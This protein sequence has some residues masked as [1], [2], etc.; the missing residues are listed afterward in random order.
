MMYNVIKSRVIYAILFFVLSVLMIHLLKPSLIYD[1]DG[2]MKEFGT[3]HNKTLFSFGVIT[4]F[5]A[6]ISF[7][8]FTMIDIIFDN[9]KKKSTGMSTLRQMNNVTV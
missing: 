1:E 8:I 4:V 7:F 2:N 5:L 9:L 6:V 3:G